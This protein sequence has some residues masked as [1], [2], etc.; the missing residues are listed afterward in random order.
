MLKLQQ[1]RVQL[2]LARQVSCHGD[3]HECA[4]HA[5]ISCRATLTR[6]TAAAAGSSTAAGTL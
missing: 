5:A 2:M 1:L 3:A 6:W 4:L